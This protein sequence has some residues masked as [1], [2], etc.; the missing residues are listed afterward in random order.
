M[1]HWI[2]RGLLLLVVLI[3]FMVGSFLFFAP[4]TVGIEGLEFVAAETSTAIR[5]WGGFFFATGLIGSAGILWRQWSLPAAAAVF[6]TSACVVFAR[7]SGISMDGMDER[8]M[9]ELRDESLGLALALGAW[10]SLWLAARR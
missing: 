7:L 10:L 5:T 6:I 4:Q 9:S 2:G 3:Y 1:L 8:Q